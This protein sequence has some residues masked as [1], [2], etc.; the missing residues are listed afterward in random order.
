MRR[1]IQLHRGNASEFDGQN[2]QRALLRLGP[3]HISV[4]DH[5]PG[6]E[7]SEP[8]LC[9]TSFI[10]GRINVTACRAPEWD[11]R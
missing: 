6:I 2:H 5:G 7:R 8:L 4:S 3:A 10:E 11:Y 9:L 1:D